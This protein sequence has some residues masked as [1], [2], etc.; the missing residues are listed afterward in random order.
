MGQNHPKNKRGI[1]LASS[2]RVKEN[3]TKGGQF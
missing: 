2:A 3:L 1:I